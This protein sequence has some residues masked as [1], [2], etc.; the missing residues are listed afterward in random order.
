MQA[1]MLSPVDTALAATSFILDRKVVL[2]VGGASGGHD[3]GSIVTVTSEELPLDPQRMTMNFHILFRKCSKKE[4]DLQRYC[5]ACYCRSLQRAQSSWQKEVWEGLLEAVREVCTNTALQHLVEAASSSSPSHKD[6]WSDLYRTEGSKTPLTL[7]TERLSGWSQD[8]VH[9]P[10]A[11]LGSVV[12]NSAANEQGRR[13][14]VQLVKGIGDYVKTIRKLVMCG[15]E[16][17]MCIV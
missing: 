4:M 10:A 8:G 3:N 17:G 6:L 13:A 7:F 15:E 16:G 2:G 14:I 9:V 11:M 12:K 5:V 1:Q